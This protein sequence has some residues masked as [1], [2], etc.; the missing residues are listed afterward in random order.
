MQIVFLYAQDERV[1]YVTVRGDDEHSAF[2]N[3][4][5]LTSLGVNRFLFYWFNLP[6]KSQRFLRVHSQHPI[7]NAIAQHERPF[8]A[9]FFN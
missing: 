4:L 5:H 1:L 9:T 2:W 6:Q 3:C 8:K 7:F